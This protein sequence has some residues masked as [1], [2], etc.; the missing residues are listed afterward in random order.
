[1]TVANDNEWAA[2]S[3]IIDDSL[4]TEGGHTCAGDVSL[5]LEF[6]AGASPNEDTT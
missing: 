1:M 4:D 5:T 6:T 3:H 2:G